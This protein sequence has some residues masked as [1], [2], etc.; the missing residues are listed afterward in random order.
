MEDLRMQ[1]K[2]LYDNQ[3]MCGTTSGYGDWDGLAGGL[4][5]GGLTLLAGRPGMGMTTLALNMIHRIARKQN[6][7]IL[8]FTPALT[9]SEVCARLLQIGL[10]VS[11][12]RLFDGSLQPAEAEAKCGEM[13]AQSKGKIQVHD[14]GS[15]DMDYIQETCF[16]IPDVQMVVV[17]SPEN[18]WMSAN[19]YDLTAQNRLRREPMDQTVR[20]LQNLAK[21]CNVPVVC[22]VRLHR[23]I[24]NRKDKRPK[25]QD[26][27]KS[28]VPVSYADQVV[29]LYRND[30]YQL[31]QESTLSCIVAKT[32]FGQ[33]GT[34]S[35]HWCWA[36][37]EI[38]E[39]ENP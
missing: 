10:G 36:N 1:L 8:F 6:G 27:E 21:S 32:P 18:L 17:D 22:T 7:T 3:E 35:L 11:A 13:L 9:Q 34:F 29:F 2:Q 16:Q 31:A 30:Y 14:I 20:K 26:L 15:L 33:T 23:S 28:N 4:V 39:T 38:S 5:R 19:R 12:G 37:D 24:E 25:L